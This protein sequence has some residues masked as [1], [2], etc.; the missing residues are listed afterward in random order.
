MREPANPP[1][2][3][4]QIQLS[5]HKDHAPTLSKSRLQEPAPFHN[6]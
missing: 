4:I 3:P 6:R 1:R 5:E 2:I